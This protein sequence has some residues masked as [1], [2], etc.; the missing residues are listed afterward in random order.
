MDDGRCFGKSSWD[1]VYALIWCIDIQGQHY[2]GRQQTAER[3][4]MSESE[5][6]PTSGG[7]FLGGVSR[8]MV[9]LMWGIL[10][11]VVIVV[12]VLAMRFY[13]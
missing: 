10:V 8:L 12:V 4:S 2:T 6:K 1:V 3:A 9:S 5:H 7:R 13:S 11:V